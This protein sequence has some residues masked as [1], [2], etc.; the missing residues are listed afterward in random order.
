MDDQFMKRE[1]QFQKDMEEYKAYAEKK[2]AV[3]QKYFPELNAAMA[4]GNMEEISRITAKINEEIGPKPKLAL[5]MEAKTPEELM[6]RQENVRRAAELVREGKMSD[7]AGVLGVSGGAG[8]AGITGAAGMAGAG[9]AAPKME[10]V[11]WKCGF[12]G[13]MNTGKFCTN[14][15]APKGN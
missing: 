14:C 7:A 9:A 13:G 3:T 8:A 12:C 6:K 10:P 2:T 11:S 5:E 1:E 15:G 4:S